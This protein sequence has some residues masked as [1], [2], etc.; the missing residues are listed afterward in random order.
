LPIPPRAAALAQLAIELDQ[1]ETVEATVN[2]SRRHWWDYFHATPGVL[3][4]TERRL[5]WVGVSPRGLIERDAGQPTAFDVEYYPYDSVTVAEGRVFFGT[6]RGV[7]LA[8]ARGRDAFIVQS[9]EMSNVRRIAGLMERRLAAIRS[10]L[11]RERRQ[12][13]YAAFLAR[14]PVYHDVKRG[15]ALSSIA[16]QYGL[17]PDSLRMLNGLPDNRIKAGQK[18]LVRPPA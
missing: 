2:V 5:I 11:E 9:N 18:L 12:Q 10:E 3:A 15:E 8:R 7:V 16:E 1:G 17:S 13:E 14:Q 4:A 6:R